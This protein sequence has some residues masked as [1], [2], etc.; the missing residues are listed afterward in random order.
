M[1]PRSASA[2]APAP[3]SPSQI[4]GTRAAYKLGG[5]TIVPRS[6]SYSGT[7]PNVAYA[8]SGQELTNQGVGDPKNFLDPQWVG[9]PSANAELSIRLGQ[10]SSKVDWVAVHMLQNSTYGI[11]VPDQMEIRCRS[12]TGERRISVNYPYAQRMDGEYVFSNLSPLGMECTDI[13]IKFTSL[14]SWGLMFMD[15][16]EMSS[17]SP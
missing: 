9:V 11:Y 1:L 5:S 17:D 15:E 2:S 14:Q 13:V 16:I 3:E 12:T 4:N 8:D 10:T 6:Y 7:R